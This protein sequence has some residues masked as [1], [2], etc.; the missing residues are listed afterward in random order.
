MAPTCD[1]PMRRTD[2]WDGPPLNHWTTG[3]T[4]AG[5]PKLSKASLGSEAPFFW[6]TWRAGS[7]G[8]EL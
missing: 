8:E 7:M 2:R 3:P 1:P 5:G 4:R 6:E